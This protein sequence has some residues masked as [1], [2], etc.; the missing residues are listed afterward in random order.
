MVN[1]F[2][3]AKDLCI[4]GNDN[5]VDFVV[6]ETDCFD[7]DINNVVYADSITLCTT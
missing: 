2:R 3:E 6:E 5:G 4:E 7:D 1:V